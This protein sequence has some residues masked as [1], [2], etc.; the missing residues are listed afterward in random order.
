MAALAKQRVCVIGAGPSGTAM[1]RAFASAKAKGEAV[2]EVV[3]YEKQG[4]AC[5]L[6]N[7]SW[8]TGLDEFG[9]P[10]HNSMYHYLWSNG[11]KEC[12][13][14][15]DYTFEEHFG[16]PIPSFPPREVLHDYIRGRLDKAGVRDTIKFKTAVRSVTYDETTK[17][18]S[19]TVTDLVSRVDTTSTFDYVVNCGGHFS[20][21]NVPHFPGFESF[22]GRILH[23]HD[24]REATEFKG[25][26]IL[27]IGTSYSAEDIAS[28]CYKYG[29]G[30][31][32]CSWR[33]APMGYHWPKNFTTHALLETIA[34]DGT[35]S[36]KDGSTARVD[37]VILCTGY[38]HHFP[39]V[40]DSLRLKTANRLW[41]DNLYNGVVLETNHKMLY[42]GMQ[43]QWFTFNM[44]DAQAWWARDL[45]AGK[46]TIPDAAARA[47][48]FKKW[49]DREGTLETDED[50]FRYQGD[51]IKALI[52][53]TDYPTFDV[54][55]V[56]DQFNT[57]EHNK[58]EDIMG[59][60]D[61]PHKSVMTGTTAPV[62]HTKWLAA[63]DD[64]MAC[65][66]KN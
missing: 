7:F 39:Y 3:C 31:I 32:H 22:N 8:R 11:P 30:E 9:E 52:A 33:T 55:G 43:D 10:V 50:M 53:E 61:C 16:K 45:I 24:F 60:R 66:M 48:H 4:D 13:E 23:A 63:L 12:L 54:D 15:A 20:T 34:P 14:F 46:I 26:S 40:A 29:V 57:W 42:I 41:C 35:C 65:Y 64:S 2:P 44:F 58:H 28:Q 36:F 27:V 59:F 6:W 25:Q 62:H 18:F 51:M 19:V 56:C 49:R 47:A 37:A 1:L 17:L 21:P 5:G 38:Q